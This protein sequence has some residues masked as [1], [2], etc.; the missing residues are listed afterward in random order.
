M[1]TL[2]EDSSKQAIVV[3][4]PKIKEIFFLLI[5]ITSHS[6]RNLLIA[7]RYLTEIDRIPMKLEYLNIKTSKPATNIPTLTG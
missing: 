7:T 3:R 5:E 2:I 6:L 1:N 4:R